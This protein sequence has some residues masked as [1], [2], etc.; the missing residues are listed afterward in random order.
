MAATMTSCSTAIMA[1]K[2]IL[3]IVLRIIEIFTS[4]FARKFYEQIVVFIQSRSFE[5]YQKYTF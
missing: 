1:T 4:A 2:S 5:L 3:Q